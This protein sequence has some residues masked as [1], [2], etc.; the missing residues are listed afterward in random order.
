MIR[1][2]GFGLETTTTRISRKVSLTFPRANAVT[3]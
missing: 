3:F 1:C 2:V